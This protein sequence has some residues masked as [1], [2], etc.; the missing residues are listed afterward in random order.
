MAD[1]SQSQGILQ[2]HPEP[3]FGGRSYKQVS[4]FVWQNLALQSA[5]QTCPTSLAKI[6]RHHELKFEQSWQI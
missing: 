6:Q 2:P 5:L 3:N 1:K 4:T